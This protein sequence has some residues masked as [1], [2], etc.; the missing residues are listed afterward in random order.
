MAFF[1][2]WLANFADGIHD[3]VVYY[4]TPDHKQFDE[5]GN[6]FALWMIEVNYLVC[7]GI[8]TKKFVQALVMP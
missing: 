4:F 1:F 7:Q 3:L 6:H 2:S 5:D 8:N